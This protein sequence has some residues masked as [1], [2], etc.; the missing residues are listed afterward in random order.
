MASIVY[1]TI[2]VLLVRI[3][4]NT[5][6]ICQQCIWAHVCCY[7][8]FK[9]V[10]NIFGFVLF[11][12]LKFTH[13]IW[14]NP[15]L[16]RI[17][18]RLYALNG[19]SFGWKVRE[20]EWE[21]EMESLSEKSNKPIRNAIRVNA[22]D[23]SQF[24]V[25]KNPIILWSIQIMLDSSRPTPPPLSSSHS[26]RSG[27]LFCQFHNKHTKAASTQSHVQQIRKYKKSWPIHCD[28]AT[29]TTNQKLS[30]RQYQRVQSL[31]SIIHVPCT[32]ARTRAHE[33][34][35]MKRT[36]LCV[37]VAGVFCLVIIWPLIANR[38]PSPHI[39]INNNNAR[40]S[41]PCSHVLCRPVLKS[42][43]RIA[44][45]LGTRRE[46]KERQKDEAAAETCQRRGGAI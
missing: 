37:C 10:S 28:A 41:F 27:F 1:N 35:K 3:T 19:I 42:Y 39:D 21:E 14:L 40:C 6:I 15:S 7:F 17:A 22:I 2:N 13:L 31:L 5:G 11:A 34:R 30:V 16:F 24:P 9:Y 33:T 18:F 45:T 32:G 43:A 8:L 26:P 20:G 12:Q 44:Y 38:V 25:A 4:I 29:K 46:W 36:R 23:D